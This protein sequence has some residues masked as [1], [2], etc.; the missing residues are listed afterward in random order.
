MEL[1]FCLSNCHKFQAK[2]SR[3]PD[4]ILLLAFL[5]HVWINLAYLLNPLILSGR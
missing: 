2:F 3:L 1:M 5:V 4:L